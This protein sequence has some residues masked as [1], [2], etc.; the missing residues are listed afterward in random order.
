MISSVAWR[1]C[2]L[3]AAK[4]RPWRLN[5]FKSFPLQPDSAQR[6]SRLGMYNIK[7]RLDTRSREFADNTQAMQ[8]LVDDLSAN[9]QTIAQGGN[10]MPATSI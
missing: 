2:A 5:W 6:H 10:E 7:T 9:V 4:P 3:A 1:P 8:S